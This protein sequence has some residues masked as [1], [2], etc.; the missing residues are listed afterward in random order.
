MCAV[1]TIAFTLCAP[2]LA[3]CK[4]TCT[5]TGQSCGTN[6]LCRRLTLECVE[7]QGLV[8]RECVDDGSVADGTSCISG[9]G[10]CTN[11]QCV[12]LRN[13]DNPYTL[14]NPYHLNT[15]KHLT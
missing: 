4:E 15:L 5:D 6:D 3:A 11:G 7:R 14:P 10:K 1:L 8:F 13:F 2:N 12:R 9:L